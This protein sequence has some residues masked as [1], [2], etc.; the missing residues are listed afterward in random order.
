M[1]FCS[2]KFKMRMQN[3]ALFETTSFSA[4]FEKT[5]FLSR[6]LSMSE[7]YTLF[8][9]QIGSD[10]KQL[11]VNF[12]LQENHTIK[13]GLAFAPRQ[14]VKE[15]PKGHLRLNSLYRILLNNQMIFWTVAV[16]E[17]GKVWIRGGKVKRESLCLGTWE[18]GEAQPLNSSTF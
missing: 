16:E 14:G 2:W 12:V 9:I 11:S 15:N 4:L 17:E 13:A 6:P 10:P 1:A 8:R 7:L 5:S 3:H 18:D